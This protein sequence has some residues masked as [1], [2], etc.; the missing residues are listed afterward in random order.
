MAL[1]RGWILPSKF[2]LEDAMAATTRSLALME[3][4]TSSERGPELPMHVMQPYPQ[5]W[6]P[7]FSR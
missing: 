5:T 1:T 7:S 2:L 6:K 4:D 3:L